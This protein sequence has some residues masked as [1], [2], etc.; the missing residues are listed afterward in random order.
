MLWMSELLYPEAAQLD[1]FAAVQ[2]Y[3]EL[4]YHCKITRE[5]YDALMQNSLGA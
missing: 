2:E 1:M 5:Q 4:F 3:F